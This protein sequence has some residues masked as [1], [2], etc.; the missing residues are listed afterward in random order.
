MGR[1]RDVCGVVSSM[2][3]VVGM[4][5]GYSDPKDKIVKTEHCKLIQSIGKKFKDGNNSIICGVGSF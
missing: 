2:F 5:Y 1:L 4:I 3:M